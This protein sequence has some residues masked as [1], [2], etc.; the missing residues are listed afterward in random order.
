EAR[1]LTNHETAA[2]NPAWSPDG[3][4]IYFLAPDPKPTERVAGE[5]AKDDV[6]TFDESFQQRHLWKIDVASGTETRVTSGDFSVLSYELSRA[7][8]RIAHHR[9]PSPN[10]GDGERGEVWVMDAAGGNA[11]A[12]TKNAVPERAASL[13]PDGSRMLFISQANEAFET[14]YNGNLFV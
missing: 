14:Y 9:A 5:K 11:A 4:S 1:R 2:D 13:S 12:L 8:T 10:F 6:Y 7:G 3:R